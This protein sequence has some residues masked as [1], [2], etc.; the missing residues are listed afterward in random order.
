[1]LST[2][3]WNSDKAMRRDVESHDS[4]QIEIRFLQSMLGRE[5]VTKEDPN[6]GLPVMD[7]Q[8][9]DLA[10]G[11]DLNM[12]SPARSSIAEITGEILVEIFRPLLN[13]DNHL[14]LLQE[15]ID[16]ATDSLFIGPDME[17]AIILKR[18]KTAFSRR[19]L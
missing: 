14:K 19:P 2:Y 16:P 18:I 9:F 6:T 15:E 4:L 1:V 5:T 10:T 13:A 12:P 3:S 7:F 11:D 8:I 17:R